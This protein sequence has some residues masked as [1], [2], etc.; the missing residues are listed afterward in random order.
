MQL[1]EVLEEYLYHCQARN[2]TPKTM[3]NKRQEY[4]HLLKFLKEKRGITLLESVT[5]HDL[6]SYIR[7]K[8]QEGLKPVSIVAKCKLI[9]AFFNWC[10]KEEG[11]LSVN[12]MDKVEI[13]KVT[14][15]VKQGLS[16]DEIQAM[17]DSFSYKSYVEARNKAIIACLADL[18]LRSIEVRT[19]LTANV[20]D[21]TILVTGKGNKERLLSISPILKKILIK[22]ERLKKLYFSERLVKSD[23]Y[24]L[25][26]TGDELSHV[27]LYNI[28]R[29]AA[30]RAGIKDK[31]IHPHLFRHF[32]AL[33]S[34]ERLDL[35]SLSLL[36]G[37]SE[38]N[39]TQIYLS[40]MSNQQ[41]LDKAIASSP[42]MNLRK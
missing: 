31:K 30:K 34:L 33:K 8:Q 17:I 32:Y 29:L 40:S 11:Y 13:P 36:L 28:T 27:G 21:S 3:I 41:L 18:G 37:H 20:R 14:K 19:L 25:S 4:N 23:N 2:F 6:K 15:K 5:E 24:F 10:V 38:V 35:H 39:T 22:F 12:P 7:G 1:E 26:Y 9:K 42:L 16:V